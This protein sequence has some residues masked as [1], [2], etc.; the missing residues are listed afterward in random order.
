MLRLKWQQGRGQK[1]ASLMSLSA[2][3][4]AIPKA[5][6]GDLWLLRT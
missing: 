1:S 4:A 2:L 3:L 6:L 5:S